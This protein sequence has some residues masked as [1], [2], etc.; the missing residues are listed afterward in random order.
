M[1]H[2]RWE[3]L[4][5]V[6]PSKDVFISYSNKNEN[7]IYVVQG[8]Y[9]EMERHGVSVWYDHGIYNGERSLQDGEHFGKNIQEALKT[10]R[11]FLLLITPDL[12]EALDNRNTYVSFEYDYAR[13][14]RKPIIPIRMN[15]SALEGQL[16]ML[17]SSLQFIDVE[18]NISA[19][20]DRIYQAIKERIDVTKQKTVKQKNCEQ[21]VEEG[22]IFE[23][24]SLIYQ[25][26]QKGERDWLQDA[27]T[28]LQKHI[29]KESFAY[30]CEE[31]D[32]ALCT[33]N[34]DDDELLFIFRQLEDIKEHRLLDFEDKRVLFLLYHAATAI[35]NHKADRKMV[36]AYKE[37][38]EQYGHVKDVSADEKISQEL[39]ER[40]SEMDCFHYQDA[41]EKTNQILEKATIIR[42]ET[43][44]LSEQYGYHI[45]GISDLAYGRILSTKGQCLAYL[46]DPQAG[47]IFEEAMNYMDVPNKRITQSYY[48]HHLLDIK[49]QERY[50]TVAYDYFHHQSDLLEQFYCLVKRSSADQDAEYSLPYALNVYIRAL[51]TFYLDEIPEKI[52]EGILNGTLWGDMVGLN[53][54]LKRQVTAHPWEMIYKYLML[55]CEHYGKHLQSQLYQENI[56]RFLQSVTKEKLTETKDVVEYIVEYGYVEYYNTIHDELRKRRWLE[57]L[58]EELQ[59]DPLVPKL[60]LSDHEDDLKQFFTF[61]FH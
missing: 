3:C 60:S 24:L 29:R 50:E 10:C 51:F 32:Q 15:H 6:K 5:L 56:D 45:S 21:A 19:Y 31:L 47:D 54:N 8:L 36:K 16:D 2:V 48:L 4:R 13:K 26:H 35:F 34:R 57:K 23:A 22:H 27:L 38:C 61:S 39:R 1:N 20:Y 41:L 7:N 18:S 14:L 59:K 11:V 58:Y 25:A 43:R 37:R 17:T 55:I 12:C 40:T 28:N 49:D 53:Y 44:K 46:R 33:N 30:A 9:K 42:Q 52:K